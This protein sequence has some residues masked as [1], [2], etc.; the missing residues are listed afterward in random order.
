MSARDHDTA[1]GNRGDAPAKGIEAAGRA[2][3]T[4][5]REMVAAL[6]KAAIVPAVIAG[7]AANADPACAR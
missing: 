6:A 7:V 2:T 5:R 4:T 1:P 3:G